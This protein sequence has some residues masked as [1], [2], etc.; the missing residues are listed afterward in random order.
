[1]KP[2]VYYQTRDVVRLRQLATSARLVDPGQSLYGDLHA[3]VRSLEAAVRAEAAEMTVLL[4]TRCRATLSALA[5][6]S[7][8]EGSFE[9]AVVVDGRKALDRLA[10]SVRGVDPG[11]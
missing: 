10:R 4:I 6:A 3:E 7:G 2:P 5:A 9:A 11:D 1:M 8:T